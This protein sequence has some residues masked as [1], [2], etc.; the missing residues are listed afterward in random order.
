MDTPIPAS[1]V[2]YLLMLKMGWKENT[3]L[4][5]DASGIVDP[6]RIN[7]N[8]GVLGLGKLAQDDEW[9]DGEGKRKAL[10]SELELTEEQMKKREEKAEKEKAIKTA[11]TEINKVFHCDLCNKQYRMITEY[12]Q[13]LGSYDHNHKKRFQEMRQMMK[14]D[15]NKKKEPKGAQVDK[16]LQR[17]MAQANA[18]Q[19]RANQQSSIPPPPS[20]PPPPSIPPPPPVDDEDEPMPP[21]PPSD[22]PERSSIKFGFG[23]PPRSATTTATITKTIPVPPPIQSQ[24]KFAATTPPQTAPIKF[25]FATPQQASVQTPNSKLGNL[26][27]DTS[28]SSTTQ[29]TLPIKFAFAKPPSNPKNEPLFK[30]SHNG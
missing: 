21:P 5:R 16:D 29:T 25:A 20:V 26:E 14:T 15:A 4:G 1:N 18:A 17:I 12:E 7:Q 23:K 8:F 11:V 28:Q 27:E 13:H 10:D 24:F 3:G 22:I 6:V 19:L 2:G 9:T 30:K